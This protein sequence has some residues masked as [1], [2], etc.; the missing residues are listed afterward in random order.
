MKD[1]SFIHCA[2]LHLD[3]PFKGLSILPEGLFRRLKEST[4]L[5][6]QR[7]VKEAMEREV[8]FVLISGDLYDGEDRSI[9]AQARMKKQMELLGEKGIQV[10][11][12]HGNHDHLNGNWL[13]IELPRQC[14]CVP[15]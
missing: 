8:D 5:S 13:K 2:D 4:F 6:F 1:I 14:A 7:I 9:K 12:I 3:S 11:I 10:F 15:I